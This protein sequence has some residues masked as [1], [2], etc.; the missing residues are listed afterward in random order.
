MLELSLLSWFVPVGKGMFRVSED[1]FQGG[2]RSFVSAD[3]VPNC[4]FAK[5]DSSLDKSD[6]SD[7][8]SLGLDGPDCSSSGALEFHLC[9]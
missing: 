3:F 9:Q 7:G 4:C 1:L 8:S 5:V 2:P 6:T